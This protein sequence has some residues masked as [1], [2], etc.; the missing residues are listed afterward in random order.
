MSP[1]L[2]NTR[3]QRNAALARSSSSTGHVIDV[4]YCPKSDMTKTAIDVVA[5]GLM[6]GI[7]LFLIGVALAMTPSE[8]LRSLDKCTRSSD[9]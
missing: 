9:F 4:R 8:L 2:Q 1:T 7:N 6:V 5:L 3:A